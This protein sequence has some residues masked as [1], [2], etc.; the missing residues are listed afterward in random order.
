MYIITKYYTSTQTI[1]SFTTFVNDYIIRNLKLN[2]IMSLIEK[3]LY[4]LI[5]YRNMN[6]KM[7]IKKNYFH[8]EFILF[9][10]I[11]M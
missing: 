11:H 8:I 7:F 5:D 9:Y 10:M 6:L 3:Y 1:M 4:V 2:I